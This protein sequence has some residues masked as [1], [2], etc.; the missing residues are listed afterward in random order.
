MFQTTRRGAEHNG[1][2]AKEWR[3]QQT[4]RGT[5]KFEKEKNDEHERF[6]KKYRVRREKSEIHK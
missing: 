3:F 2:C 6:K 1:R 5:K 4:E